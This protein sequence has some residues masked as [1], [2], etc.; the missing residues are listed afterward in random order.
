LTRRIFA[1]TARWDDRVGW[2]FEKGWTRTFAG[3]SISSYE[4]FTLSTFPEIR[5]QPSYFKKEVRQSQ[6]MSYNELAA[7]IADLRQSGFDTTPLRV[8]LSR[9]LAYPLIILVMAVLAIPFSLLAG[10]RG[11]VAGIGAG[12]GVAITYWVIAA[13]FENLGNV[14]SLP[15]VLAAWS[16]DM[17]FAIAGT[18]LLLRTPT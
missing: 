13:V 2:V 7:Y 6:E 14:N 15:A 11:S 17:L 9:K 8:Q 1:Q 16:P 10:K 3:E 4:P 18:Y 12:I 5:E